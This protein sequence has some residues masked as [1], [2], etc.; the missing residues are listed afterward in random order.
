MSWLEYRVVRKKQL[1]LYVTDFI[2]FKNLLNLRFDVLVR[3][4][5]GVKVYSITAAEVLTASMQFPKLLR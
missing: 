2:G 1:I 4:D 3:I 5:T